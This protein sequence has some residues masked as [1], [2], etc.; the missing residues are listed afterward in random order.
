MPVYPRR[1]QS[2]IWAFG[3]SADLI[4]ENEDSLGGGESWRRTVQDRSRQRGAMAS[5]H[6]VAAHWL[7][8]LAPTDEALK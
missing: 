1:R 7:D 5:I 8:I 6:T 3:I 2:S 4:S